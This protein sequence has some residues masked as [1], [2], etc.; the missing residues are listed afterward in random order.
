MEQEERELYCNKA[1]CRKR[2]KDAPPC[3]SAHQLVNQAKSLGP[4]S[5]RFARFRSRTIEASAEFCQNLP[6]LKEYAESGDFTDK[7]IEE[8]TPIKKAG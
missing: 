1:F 4:K 2:F 8:I 3:F 5:Q 6:Q 7:S